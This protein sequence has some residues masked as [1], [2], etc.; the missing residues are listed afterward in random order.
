MIQPLS[1]KTALLAGL[2]LPS[3]GI[4]ATEDNP[5]IELQEVLAPGQAC[6]LQPGKALPIF[7]TRSAKRALALLLPD[8]PVTILAID[9][10]GLKVRGMGK[11]GPLTGWIGQKSALG[12]DAAKLKTLA[13]VYERQITIESLIA[14]KRPAIGMTFRELS[15][16]YGPATS[17]NI[18]AEGDARTETAVWIHNE[19]VDLND[20]LNLGT[21]AALL[22]MEVETG[23][24]TVQLINGAANSIDLNLE[25][26]AADIP[27]V[28]KPIVPPFTLTPPGPLAA[29]GL[30]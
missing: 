21:D 17:H 10:F 18:V 28:P 12:G 24:I 5:V 1:L 6:T 27:T 4:F 11:N 23:R 30:R 20:T 2:L 26:V 8:K 13:A 9:R 7:D 22:K 3:A 25:G 14:R 16:I 15:R 29:K 19:K